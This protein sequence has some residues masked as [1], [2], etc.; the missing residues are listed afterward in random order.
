MSF[1]LDI[2]IVGAGAGGLVA[3]IAAAEQG[4]AVAILEKQ[5]RPGG[6]SSLS[7]GSVPGAGSRFQREAGVVDSP[8]R[9]LADMEVIAPDNDCPELVRRLISESAA[10]VEWL[11]DVA[12]ARIALVTD[13]RHVGHSAPRLHAPASRRGQ[14]LVDDLLRAV[15]AR[16]VPLAVGNAATGLIVEDGMVM[17]AMTWNGGGPPQPVR[18]RKTILAMNGFA[19]NA[20]LLSR[21]CPEAAGL[22]YFGAPGSTGEAVE[23]G[24]SLGAALG[25]MAAYQG[26]AAVSDPHG[27]IVSWTTVEKGGIVVDRRGK[28]FGNEG[29]GYSAFTP[30][31]QAQGGPCFVIFDRRIHDIAARESEFVELAEYGGVKSAED[32]PSI[33][34]IIGVDGHALTLTIA[35]SN[36]AARGEAADPF[37]RREFGLGP[38]EG[39]LYACRVSPGIFHTQGG[40]AVDQDARVLDRA[41][42]AIPNVFAVGG[43]AAG[44]SGRAGAAGYASGNGLLSAI[45]LGKLAGEAAARETGY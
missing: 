16:D 26:Y 40:L 4:A 37:G 23:W 27:G 42:R 29:L 38:I 12:G 20:T 14:D 35:A 44:I 2:L 17:G 39:R 19:A 34:A 18:A 30:N 24:I 25:N 43:S 21:F 9:F 36:A 28:R 5:D 45:G 11:V 3:A 13:Y 7:T 41:G 33:A 31:V 22:P 15:E 6:N 8:E 1:D 10:T 32:A